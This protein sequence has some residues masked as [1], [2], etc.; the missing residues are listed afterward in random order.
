MKTCLLFSLFIALLSC[1]KE[2]SSDFYVKYSAYNIGYEVIGDSLYVTRVQMKFD[3]PTSATPSESLS[4]KYAQKI[5]KSQVE[6]LKNL[7]AKSGFWNTEKNEY[8]APST[9]RYYPYVLYIKENGR[10][11]EIIYRSHPNY[12]PSPKFLEEIAQFLNQMAN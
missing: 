3:N 4:E 2:S 5:S 10:E 9:E 6:D 11:K 8:G 12:E 7:I 1:Q